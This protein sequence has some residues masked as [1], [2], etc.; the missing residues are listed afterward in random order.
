MKN[1]KR[2][3]ALALFALAFSGARAAAKEVVEPVGNKPCQIMAGDTIRIPVTGIAGSKIEVTVN[4]MAGKTNV[5]Q[6]VKRNGGMNVI[7]TVAEDHEFQ[8][9]KGTTAVKVTVTPPNGNPVVTQYTI[10]AK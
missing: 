9:A 1:C 7:G 6:V 3:C 10:E 2:L 5:T 8:A 4:G